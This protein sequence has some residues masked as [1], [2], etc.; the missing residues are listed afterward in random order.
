MSTEAASAS[1]VDPKE[2]EYYTRL[3]ERWWDD[4]GA[5][6]PIHTLNRLR[7]DWILERITPVA[8]KR[9][10]D[11]GCG[12]GL[13]SEAMARAGAEVTGVDVTE[14]NVEVARLHA[15]QSGLRIDYRH[16]TAEALAEAGERFDVVLNMEVVEHVADLTGFMDACCSLVADDG[17]MFVATLNRTIAGL[18]IGILGA[19]Y[20]MRLLPVGTHQWERF[21][22][23]RELAAHLE[24]GGLGVVDRTGVRVNPLSRQMALT[25]WL[26]VNYMVH[27]RRG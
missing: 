10:L 13:L 1:S 25:G 17:H 7:K 18:V 6:W 4:S 8:G 2:V 20:V 26:G 14:K 19:E 27:A 16:T 22:K 23:P 21:V 15:E 9:V 5:M 12:G 11:I 3:A 24:R